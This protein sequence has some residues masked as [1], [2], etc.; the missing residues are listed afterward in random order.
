MSKRHSSIRKMIYFYL[1]GIFHLQYALSFTFKS[2]LLLP[3]Y[4]NRDTTCQPAPDIL[5]CLRLST[6]H[7]GDNVL[8]IYLVT[9]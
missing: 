3:V 9:F 7:A 4:S 8:T 2:S 5:S 6:V 1:S